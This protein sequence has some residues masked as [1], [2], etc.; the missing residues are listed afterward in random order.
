[1]LSI[2]PVE[3]VV[4]VRDVVR[5]RSWVLAVYV[6]VYWCPTF[7]WGL[8]TSIGGRTN[9]LLKI[10]VGAT[11]V[12]CMPIVEFTSGALFQRALQEA[13]QYGI[14]TSAFDADCQFPHWVVVKLGTK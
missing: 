11:V 4:L 8:N 1:V 6:Q 9:L 13:F 10:G 14:L 12:E 2:L 5:S 3:I 7:I